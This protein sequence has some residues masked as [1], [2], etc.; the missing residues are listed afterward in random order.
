MAYH[1]A[2]NI[3]KARHTHTWGMVRVSVRK[4]LETAEYRIRV[5]YLLNEASTWTAYEP[6]DYFT[7]DVF[8]AKATA[9]RMAIEFAPPRAD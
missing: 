8:D 5:H 3:L 6:A 9:H 1:L 7:D 2:A 4:D